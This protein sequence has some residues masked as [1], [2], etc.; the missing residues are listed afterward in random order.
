MSIFSKSLI[1]LIR[2][3]QKTVG[4]MIGELRGHATCRFLPT[5]SEYSILAIEK[6]GF[7]RG[8][9]KSVKRVSRCHPWSKQRIDFP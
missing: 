6:Y 5:C 4:R 3:Y 8:I 7:F 2:A 1:F 9:L